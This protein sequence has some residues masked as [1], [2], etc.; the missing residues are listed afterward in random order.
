MQLIETRS[1]LSGLVEGTL[2]VWLAEP[3]PINA[4][5]AI[6]RHEYNDR[7][8][9]KLQ[10]C[11]VAGLRAVIMRPENHEKSGAPD[12]HKLE[13]MCTVRLREHLRLSDEAEVLVEVEGDEQWWR[14]DG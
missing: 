14:H 7:E 6:Q 8:W 12:I 1:G 5:P 10:R 4:V 3:Y 13:L 9:I 2:N 11:R